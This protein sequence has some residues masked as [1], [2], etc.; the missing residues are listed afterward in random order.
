MALLY[1]LGVQ[2]MQTRGSQRQL[3][4]QEPG[5][6]DQHP[7]QYFCQ[8]DQEVPVTNNQYHHYDYINHNNR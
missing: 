3:F 5:Q 8:P 7:C 4:Q 1:S 2:E 6:P